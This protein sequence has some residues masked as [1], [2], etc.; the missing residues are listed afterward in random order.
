MNKLKTLT[1]V[2]SMILLISMAVVFTGCLGGGDSRETVIDLDEAEKEVLKNIRSAPAE[3]SFNVNITF[4]EEGER[5]LQVRHEGEIVMEHMVHVNDG[6]DTDFDTVDWSYEDD[7]LNGEIYAPVEVETGTTETIDVDVENSI[8]EKRDI[9]IQ[10]DYEPIKEETV[11]PG[12]EI[13]R[14]I[15]SFPYELERSK[16]P[17]D[18]T[19]EIDGYSD[20]YN[21]RMIDIERPDSQEQ[22]NDDFPALEDQRPYIFYENDG[23]LRL[24]IADREDAVGEFN[25]TLIFSR[26]KDVKEFLHRDAETYLNRSLSASEYENLTILGLEDMNSLKIIFGQANESWLS[27]DPDVLVGEYK[28]NI[29]LEAVNLDLDDVKITI[30]E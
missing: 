14:Y 28:I 2:V 15:F 1:M 25:E 22:V 8:D 11:G 16:I 17:E 29:T 3:I 18:L 13:D 12:G 4:E 5:T 23:Q 7:N 10:L 9:V 27:G 6:A 20:R 26:E 30:E 19:I 21:R 24:E